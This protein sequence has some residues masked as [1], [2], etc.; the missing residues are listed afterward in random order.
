M[1]KILIY[2]LLVLFFYSCNK[3]NEIYLSN[4]YGKN[5]KK[6]LEKVF[7]ENNIKSDDFFYF[8]DEYNKIVDDNT[9]IDD[10]ELVNS[11]NE[12]NYDILKYQES[13]DKKNLLGINCRITTYLLVKEYIS[14]NNKKINDSNLFFDK[15][16]IENMSKIVFDD[17]TYLDYISFFSQIETENT[18]EY[19]RHIKIIENNFKEKQIK[20]NNDKIKVISVFFHS[21]LDEPNTLFIGH[22]GLLFNYGSKFLFIEKLSP[23]EPYQAIIFNNKRELNNYLMKKY[24]VD[25]TN[26]TSSPIIFEN[27]KLLKEYE[28]IKN[29][30]N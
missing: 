21:D 6:I 11:F 20:F 18:L 1:K 2:L 15:E 23:I 30:N 26:N 17:K 28:I 25:E 16:M 8:L 5:S 12:I 10:F 4:I 13:L 24:D 27:D 29:K 9:L 7:N 22:I 3:N 19:I 14:I